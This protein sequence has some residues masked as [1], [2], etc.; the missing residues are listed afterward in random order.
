MCTIKLI[1]LQLAHAAN[2]KTVTGIQSTG[3][4]NVATISVIIIIFLIVLS[5]CQT[6]PIIK[7]KKYLVMAN[8]NL[9]EV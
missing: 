4:H 2:F 9:I 3:N 8:I 1:L 6:D 5:D 7:M